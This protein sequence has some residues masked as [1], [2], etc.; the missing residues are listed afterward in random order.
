MTRVVTPA[1]ADP[2]SPGGQPRSHYV[3]VRGREIHVMEWGTPGSQPVMMWHG[4]ARTGRDFDHLAAALADRFH[5]VAPDTIGRGLSEWSDQPDTDYCLDVYAQLAAGV[6]SA[7]GW[8]TFDWVGTSMGGSLGIRAAATVL[9]GRIRRLLIND[10]GPTFPAAPFTRIKTYIARPPE[11]A[12]MGELIDYFRTIY[13]PFGHHT[14]AQW[15]HMAETSV[16][17]LANGKVTTHY[18]PAIVRQMFVF[19][20]D[21]E[22]WECWDRIRTPACVLHGVESDLLLPDIAREMAARG[23][24]ARVVEVP[25]CGHAPALNVSWQFDIVRAFLDGSA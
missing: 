16:R 23:P 25:G 14:K 24:R 13:K 17:R 4:L 9:E 7:M 15:H 11:F 6:A 5:I 20:D 12:T 19:P 18:D 1:P 2:S 10:I 3:K 21:Y 22:L 8:R